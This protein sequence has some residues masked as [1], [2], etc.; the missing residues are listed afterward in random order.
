MVCSGCGA[1]IADK[2]IVC[3]RCGTPTAVPAA[4]RRTTGT[5]ARRGLTLSVFLAVLALAL[6]WGAAVAPHGSPVHF[7]LAG[8]GVVALVVALVTFYRSR[9]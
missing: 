1:T 9:R 8:S 7:A 3:Y 6:E 2:A 5:P 4:P